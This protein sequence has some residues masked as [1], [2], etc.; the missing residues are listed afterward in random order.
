MVVHRKSL[1]NRR[2]ATKK[3]TTTMRE[4]TT[5]SAHKIQ[6]QRLHTRHSRGLN[7]VRKTMRMIISFRR[8]RLNEIAS[9]RSE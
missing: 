5:N 7:D 3:T 1:L 9:R 4:K 8:E 2:T 6:Q